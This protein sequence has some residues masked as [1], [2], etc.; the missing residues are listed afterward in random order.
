M[1]NVS[2]M[3]A[4]SLK[5]GKSQKNV[6]VGWGSKALIGFLSSIGKD[7]SK[8]LDQIGAAEVVKEYIRQKGLLQKDKKKHVICDDKIRSLSRKSKL[9]YNRIY[10]LLER[11]IAENLTSE[12]ETLYSSED[13]NDSVMKKKARTVS[14]E[15]ST[16]K[17]TSEI[18]KGCFASLVR[19]NIKLSYLKRSLF[20]DL[21]KDPDTF[22]S[23]VIGCFDRVKNDPKDFSY[24]MPKRLYQ[25][26]EVTSN[27]Q[28]LT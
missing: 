16:P 24:Q 27:S 15:S 2:L 19:D 6:Y 14:Y 5:K 1:A 13:N 25:L 23:K 3:L 10:S 26:G 7:T 12:D 18:N 4:W 9:I 20:M 8:S 11:R 28:L 21:L 22:G 17:R